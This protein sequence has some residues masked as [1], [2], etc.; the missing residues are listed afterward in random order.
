MEFNSLMTGLF[1]LGGALIAGLVLYDRWYLP[2]RLRPRP[3]PV[4]HVSVPASGPDTA[5][6]PPEPVPEPATE[7][8]DYPEPE[9]PAPTAAP[10]A[11]AAPVVPAPQPV[12]SPAGVAPGPLPLPAVPPPDPLA[13]AHQL[14]LL[15]PL[16]DALASLTLPQPV[17]GEAVLAVAPGTRRVGSKPF[18]LEGWNLTTQAWERPQAGHRYAA[19]QAGVQLANHSGPLNEIEFSEFQLKV[20]QLAH[21]L[22]AQ[23]DGP[24]MMHEV[25]R[26][27][28]LDHF[29]LQ[30]GAQLMF[31]LRANHAAWSVTYLTQQAA[32][33]GFVHGPVPGQLVLPGLEFGSAPVLVLEFPS[34]A[35]LVDDPEQEA[36]TEFA[37]LL[38]VPHVPRSEYPFEHLYDTLVTLAQHMDGTVTDVDGQPL[39]QEV[40]DQIGVDLE[41][42]YAALAQRQFEAGSALARRL[43]S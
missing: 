25:E 10:A 12:A 40:M 5:H 39:A 11:P 8:H 34:E 14:H 18:A 23:V 22:G 4:R 42:L 37:L 20:E 3:G 30:H 15:H 41:R 28:E 19:L 21:A 1:I 33:L 38:D 36:L 13:R 9:T 16:I 29:A 2:R 24:D 43:F 31:A 6:Q 35:A 32:Q 7:Y 26:A 17:L 27:R